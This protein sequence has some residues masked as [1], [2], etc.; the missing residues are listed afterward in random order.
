M[1][2]PDIKVDLSAGRASA[3]PLHLPE[4]GAFTISA[5]NFVFGLPSSSPPSGAVQLTGKP[6]AFNPD[7]NGKF[8]M[9]HWTTSQLNLDAAKPNGNP[10]SYNFW[11]GINVEGGGSAW[12]PVYR[13]FAGDNMGED[14]DV[15][16]VGDP[17]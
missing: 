17:E 3:Q 12:F 9:T 10:Q 6:I 7:G 1:T 16:V 13:A 5:S 11:I 4:G 15:I 8:T 2:D 14:L